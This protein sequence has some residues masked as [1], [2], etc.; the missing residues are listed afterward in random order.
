MVWIKRKLISSPNHKLELKCYSNMA[1]IPL[2]LF[3]QWPSEQMHWRSI[4]D[5]WILCTF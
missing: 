3:M 4:V 1:F 2:G 5:F